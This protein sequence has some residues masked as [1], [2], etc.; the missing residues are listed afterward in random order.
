MKANIYNTLV[1]SA[2]KWPDQLAIA[3]EQGDLTYNEL[4]QRTEI[5]KQTLLSQGT[6]QGNRV[7]L[8]TQHNRCFIIG[9]YASIG[10]GCVTMPLAHYQKSEEITKA[11][12]EARIHF[13]LTDNHA[14]AS[15]GRNIRQTE[16]F[17]QHLYFS[18][19]GFPT[20]EKTVNFIPDAAV[21]RFTSGVTGDAKC[22]ILS[23]QSVLERIHA[24]NEGFNLSENDRIV[25]VLPMAFHFVV[26]IMLYIRYG[27]SIIICDDFLADSILEK[28][29]QYECTFLYAS[30]MHIRL[31]ASNK[32]HYPLPRLKR[33]ISTTTAIGPAI[34]KAFEEKYQVPVSQVFGIIEVGLPIMNLHQSSEHPEAVGSTLPSYSVAILNDEMKPLPPGEIG[35]L[36]IKGP[37]MFDGYLSPPTLRSAILKEGWFLTGDLA[38]ITNEGLIEIKGR[39]KNLINVSGNKVFPDEVEEVIQRYPGIVGAKIYGQKHMLMGEIVVADVVLES[40]VNFDPEELIL[41][42]RQLLSS[43]K[44]PQRINVVDHIEMTASGKIKRT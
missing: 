8:I 22:V 40:T 14:V 5:L 39:T 4:L 18:E 33:V 10:C 29:S 19:T 44:I 30:P 42:C 26:S 34:C 38:S 15:L 31:L 16:I 1:T 9:L 11:L 27:C 12:N 3:D 6:Q 21:M 20:Q 37:G 2:L 28:A 17:G 23:H 24:A 43:F 32:K 35:H 36:A 13:I 25:W 7:A 41:Y